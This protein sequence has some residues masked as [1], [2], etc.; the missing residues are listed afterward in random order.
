M[1][2]YFYYMAIRVC[3]CV[4][5]RLFSFVFKHGPN[6]KWFGYHFNFAFCNDFILSFS[7]LLLFLIIRFVRTDKTF[8]PSK[9]IRVLNLNSDKTDMSTK[10]LRILATNFLAF[11][12]VCVEKNKRYHRCCHIVPIK[13]SQFIR[14]IHIFR[15]CII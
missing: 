1:K 10:R 11:S 5:V 2:C 9:F 15:I 8:T 13:Q 3:A 4:C 12:G 7:L 6:L 14:H